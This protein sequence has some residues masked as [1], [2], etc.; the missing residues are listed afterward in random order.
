MRV[1]RRTPG[2]TPL[3]LGV[4]ESTPVTLGSLDLWK[5]TWTSLGERVTVW[6]RA[7]D[8]SYEL[9]AYSVVMK[10]RTVVFAAGEVSNGVWV[11]FRPNR[12]S[13]RYYYSRSFA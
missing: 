4:L 5:L 1:G 12:I 2:W 8:E 6:P 7:E 13:D 10:R 9:S 3:A 11:F